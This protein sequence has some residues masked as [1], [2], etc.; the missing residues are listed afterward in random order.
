MSYHQEFHDMVTE[1]IRE[2]DAENTAL[3][4]IPDPTLCK[5][6]AQYVRGLLQDKLLDLMDLA[7][8][9]EEGIEHGDHDCQPYLDVVEQEAE[10]VRTILRALSA[11]QGGHNAQ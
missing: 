4:D 11:T 8:D 2:L 6:H 7:T 9:L 5:D 1:C 10:T 3:R